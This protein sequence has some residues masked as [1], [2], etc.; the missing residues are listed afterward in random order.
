AAPRLHGVIAIADRVRPA[1]GS[2][3][4]ALH[5]AGI[6]RVVMLTGD[7]RAAAHTV[8]DTRGGAGIGGDEARA[9]LLPAET[10][11]A[12]HQLR[13]RN[14]RVLFVGDGINDAPA[15]AAADVGVAMGSAG[16][17]VALDTADI[18]LMAD[19]LSRL[20]VAIRRARKAERI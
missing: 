9:G 18:A 11:A 14:P 17:D 19:D 4:R 2:A 13:G 5:A 7:H 12:V 8:A 16:T 1:A 3:L 15:L 10:V 20:P 6:Q